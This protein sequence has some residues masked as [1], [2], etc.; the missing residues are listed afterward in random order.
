MRVKV[1]PIPVARALR[2]LGQD[3]GYARRRRRIPM[4]LAAERAGISRAT[5]TKIE[6]G[7]GGVS[8]GAYAKVLF[9]MGMIDRLAVMVDLAADEVGL[10]LE[11]E[12]LPKRIRYSRKESD[13]KPR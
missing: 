6:K 12:K 4:E 9:I 1:T 13:S 10:G 2:K 8:L 11:A 7:D 3:L 5:L